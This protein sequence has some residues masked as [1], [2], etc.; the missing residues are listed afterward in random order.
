M[1]AD[2]KR[3]LVVGASRGVGRATAIELGGRGYDVALAFATNREGAEKTAAD[4]PSGCTSVLIQ[5]DL[6]TDATGIVAQAVDGLGGLDTVVVTAVPVIVGPIDT[7]TPEEANRAF[8]VT[9]HGFRELALAARPHLAPGGSIIAVSS[10]GSD[11]TAAFY[12]ALGPAKAAL[13]A[14]VRYLAVSLGRDRIRV[15][16]IAPGMID[17]PDH[18]VDAPDVSAL[19]PATAKR[20]PLGRQLPTPGDIARTIAGLLSDDMA[21]VTGQILKVDGGYSLP[22]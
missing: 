9:V 7:V 14:T 17:D 21:F 10:L 19:L 13:E 1:S 18:V 22:L 8:D 2:R 15:N 5:C 3:A 6:A 20:T 12:G 4:L 11:R 16:G